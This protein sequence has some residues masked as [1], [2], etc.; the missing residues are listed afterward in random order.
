M[1]DT[2]RA[3]EIEEA[4]RAEALKHARGRASMRP[5]GHC[6]FCG[7]AAR[8]IFCGVE[9]RDSF[10]HEREARVRAGR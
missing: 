2:D 1:D 6:Y 4:A 10:Q 9:C 5:L 8:G 3:S 7:E